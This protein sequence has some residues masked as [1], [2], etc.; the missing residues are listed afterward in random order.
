MTQ[1][2]FGSPTQFEI[3]EINIAGEDVIGFFLSIS[4]Y[5]NIYMPVIT[6]NIVILDS[7]GG[8]FIQENKIEFIE[9]IEFSFKNAKGDTL[10]FKGFL[11][12]LRNEVL[13]NSKKFYTIDF[14]SK[15]VR[16]NE[17]TRIV[18]AFKDAKPKDIVSDMAE[19]LGGKIDSKSSG[20]PMNYIGSRKRPVDVIKYVLTHGL[21]D[22]TQASEQAES[23]EEEAKGTTGFLFWETLDGFRFETIDDVNAGKV[24]TPHKEFNRKLTNRSLAMDD[25]MHTIVGVA[26]NQI[27]DFQTKLRSGAFSSM[28]ISFDMDS[29]EYKE[30]K[31]YNDTNMTDKQKEMLKSTAITRYFSKPISNQKFMAPQQCTPSQPSTGDQSRK[32]LNQ[33]AGRQNTFSD[34]TGE[35]T[36]YPQFDFRA[37]DPFD[38]KIS[39]IKADK[40]AQG[41][42]DKKHSGR[43]IIQQVG[44]HFFQ[45]GRAYTVITTNRST[46]QQDDATSTREQSMIREARD[47][48]FN[49]GTI[50]RRSFDEGFIQL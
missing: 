16:K 25:L 47:L 15:A 27:G 46:I 49:L 22:R 45:D 34:Q 9:E 2:N 31:Y 23:K 5:E 10:E 12:G 18:K 32:Y 36:L 38:C 26:F 39:N 24:G 35:F 4:I 40:K 3:S 50:I 37:G 1:S 41:G 44:H 8:G 13:K 29:G 6:G 17:E 14:S 11:N 7:D 30:Y 19:K 33:N 42:Y 20:I 43:Y 48:G 28:N 21:S